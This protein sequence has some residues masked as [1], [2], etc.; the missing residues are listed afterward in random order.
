MKDWIKELKVGD[1]AT[2]MLAGKLPV[3]M[4]VREVKD[5]RLVM[6]AVEKE[7][8]IFNGGWEFCRNTGAEIDDYLRWGPEYGATGS[9]LVEEP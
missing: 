7:G 2:R 3:K 1:T 6:D 9:F 8:V 5:D 4:V